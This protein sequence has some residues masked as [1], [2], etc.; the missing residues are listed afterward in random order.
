[1]A[2]LGGQMFLLTRQFVIFP[3]F[4]FLPWGWGN[5]KS[6]VL[7][8]LVWIRS[9]AD[10]PRD[11]LSGSLWHLCSDSPLEVW[12]WLQLECGTPESGHPWSQDSIG[13]YSESHTSTD[14]KLDSS[15]QGP[16]GLHAL[17]LFLLVLHICKDIV[18]L[19]QFTFIFF[20]CRYLLYLFL[21]V[22]WNWFKNLPWCGN[23]P[24]IEYELRAQS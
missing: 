15:S 22:P 8:M 11:G 5:D 10:W 17:F 12:W 19:G 16:P 23:T 7:V 14:T 6:G 4:C 1:M 20:P 21:D 9:S 3:I 13:W 2:W 18:Y 24:S